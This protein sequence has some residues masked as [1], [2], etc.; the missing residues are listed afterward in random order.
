M[1]KPTMERSWWEREGEGIVHTEWQHGLY[2]TQYLPCFIFVSQSSRNK[3]P[4]TLKSTI[5]LWKTSLT[6]WD[7]H[8]FM[9]KQNFCHSMQP[10]TAG[11]SWENICKSVI[12]VI[13]LVPSEKKI[14]SLPTSVTAS[15]MTSIVF[16]IWCSI[17]DIEER[18]GK[19]TIL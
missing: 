14:I 8:P 18:R 11:L 3:L 17:K 4:A 19:L 15:G 2:Y 10:T 1:Q 13:S 7:D 6:C 12:Y 16:I 5:R 9:G